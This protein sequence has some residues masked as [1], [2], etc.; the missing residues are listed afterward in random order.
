[1]CEHAKALNPRK[2]GSESNDGSWPCVKCGRV[3][4][5]EPEVPRR[6][7]AFEDAFLRQVEERVHRQF[8]VDAGPFVALVRARLEKGQREYG[9]ASLRDRTVDRLGEAIEEPCDATAW[10]L[11]D[12]QVRNFYEDDDGSGAYQYHLL[13]AA[14]HGA[15]QDHHLRRAR[16]Y[17]KAL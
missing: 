9:D 15:A 16:S 4:P 6:D 7:A 13:E 14:L 3:Q 2:D 11:L 12:M 5:A 10:A 1:V 8:G 17:A